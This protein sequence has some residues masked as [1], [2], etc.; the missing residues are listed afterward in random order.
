VAGQSHHLENDLVASTIYYK[1]NVREVKGCVTHVTLQTF[2]HSCI[3][4]PDG[5][6]DVPV[7]KENTVLFEI[8]V[9]NLDRLR[10]P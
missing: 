9:L 3:H 10:T 4:N 6:K 1:L 8:S 7:G 5:G 2:L